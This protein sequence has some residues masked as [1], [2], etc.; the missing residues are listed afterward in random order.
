MVGY[1]GRRTRTLEVGMVA[2]RQ[3]RN[4]IACVAILLVLVLAVAHISL[5]GCARRPPRAFDLAFE[6]INPRSEF[7]GRTLALSDLY[8]E[9]G[10]VL[11]FTASWCEFCREQMPRLQEFYTAS[12][13]PMVFVA[14]DE[15]PYR[16]NILTVAERAG[17]TAPLLFVPASEAEAVGKH[18]SYEVIPATYFIDARGRIHGTHQ[19]EISAERLGREF[20]KTLGSER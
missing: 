2:F 3:T 11:Q 4:S 19:G 10:V 20:E 9:Q 12:K 18:Y 1:H 17:L 5:T 8:A 14:A 6:D 16:E 15:G 13:T 7:H